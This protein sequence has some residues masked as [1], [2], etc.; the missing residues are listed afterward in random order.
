[1]IVT[2]PSLFNHTADLCRE[3]GIPSIAVE[4]LPHLEGRVVFAPDGNL[5]TS[6]Q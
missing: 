1:V 4:N 6:Q 3:Y 5:Y 2:N